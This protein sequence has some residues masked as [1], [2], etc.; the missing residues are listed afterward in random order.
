MRRREE[1]GERRRNEK[2]KSQ[3]KRRDEYSVGQNSLPI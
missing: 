2:E 3:G 1:R